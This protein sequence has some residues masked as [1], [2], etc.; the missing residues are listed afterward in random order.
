MRILFGL[1]TLAALGATAASAEPNRLS[2]VDYLQ[3]ARCVGLASSKTLASPDQKAL[4][5]WFRVE[6]RGRPGFIVDKADEMQRDAQSQANHADVYAR[7]RL[8]AELNGAC[9]SLRS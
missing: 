2:D 1:A 6:T 3:A 9:A 7:P 5:A 4:V 8:E